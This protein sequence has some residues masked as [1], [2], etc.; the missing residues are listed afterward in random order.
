M[1]PVGERNIDTEFGVAEKVN[2][3]FTIR[4]TPLVKE[5]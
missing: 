3:W 1:G 2:Q 4:T 5:D